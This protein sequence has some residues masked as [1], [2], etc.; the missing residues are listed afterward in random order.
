MS[1]DAADEHQWQSLGDWVR[2]RA[3]GS[4]DTEGPVPFAHLL[5]KDDLGRLLSDLATV[6]AEPDQH[7]ELLDSAELIDILREYAEIAGWGG[8]ILEG[9][10]SP[11]APPESPYT[12]DIPVRDLKT[13]Q[14][15]SPA[16]RRVVE[17]IISGPL[18]QSP[19]GI[20][21]EITQ[22]V[23]KLPDR[24][25]WQVYLP[26]G[27]RLRYYIDEPERTVRVTYLGPHPDS[28]NEGRDDAVRQA[29][30][31]RRLERRK[32]GESG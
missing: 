11:V 14:A 9:I 15:A 2:A 18:V 1:P 3:Q 5:S 28:R 7:G 29:V 12:V 26:D 31:R 19:H 6:L 16:V 22:R 4:E 13:L 23:K 25:L 20:A 24:D 27:F 30:H 21:G 32:Q 17:E 8:P 10:R